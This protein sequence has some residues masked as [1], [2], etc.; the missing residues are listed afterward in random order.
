M[1]Y[2]IS[3][4]ALMLLLSSMLHAA[5]GNYGLLVS[6]NKSK[7]YLG[8]HLNLKL[9]FSYADLEDYELPDL[10][11]DGFEVKELNSSDYKEESNISV[12][13][14][15]YRLTPQKSGRFIIG[16]LKADIQILGKDYQGLNNR[17]K[18]I[19]KFSIFSNSIVIKV[20]PLP[21]NVSVIGNYELSATSSRQKIK[22]GE[23]VTLTIELKGSGNI[24]NLDAI[25]LNIPNAT[26][27]IKERSVEDQKN[28][29]SK[30]FEIIS[31]QNYTI[32]SL[33]L[34]YFDKA[35]GIVKTTQSRAIHIEVEDQKNIQKSN[36][37][38]N[39]YYIFGLVSILILLVLLMLYKK[40]KPST[41]RP[42]LITSVKKSKNQETLYRLM[43]VH[44]GRD[45]TL[46]TLIYTLENK[47]ESNI[48]KI[49]KEIIK[50][51]KDKACPVSAEF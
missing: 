13:E 24:K 30:I 28:T 45:R 51:L 5:E 15:N 19:K 50:I 26:S 32:P 29:Y 23:I 6:T 43:V 46:D 22:P 10:S 17:F 39:T 49:K 25:T 42:T 2:R 14:I 11:L 37:K 27:Y 33:E 18:Y 36:N 38:N 41:G 7:L 9:T 16:D 47:K 35:L 1:C 3:K 20:E 8:E 34:V 44:L 4:I 21:D 31:D 48:K 12:E 40:T